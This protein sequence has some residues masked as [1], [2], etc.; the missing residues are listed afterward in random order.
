[1]SFCFRAQVISNLATYGQSN[2]PEAMVIGSLAAI[3][4]SVSSQ[5]KGWTERAHLMRL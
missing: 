2:C 5:E 3:V 4:L 1:M